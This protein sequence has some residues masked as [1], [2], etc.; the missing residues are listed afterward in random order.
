M[1]K[2]VDVVFLHK[3]IVFLMEFKCGDDEYKAFTF[4]Q[5]Y[6]YALD[7]RNFQKESHDKLLVPIMISTKAPPEVQ[8]LK[9]YDRILSRLNVTLKILF[10]P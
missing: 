6:D 1:G 3:N 9:E 4:D 5:V 10:M 7:L 8:E 2:R